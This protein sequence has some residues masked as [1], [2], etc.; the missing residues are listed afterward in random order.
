[1]LREAL[2]LIREGLFNPEDPGLFV[3]LVDMLLEEDRYMVLADFDAYRRRQ[4]EVDGR[5][6]DTEAWTRMSILNVA[7]MSHF[8]SDRTITQYNREIWRVESIPIQR[9]EQSE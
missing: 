6:R 2:D 5:Y 1:L 4:E 7:R 8:S 3:P 9:E